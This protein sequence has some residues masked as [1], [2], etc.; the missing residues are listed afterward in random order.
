L[1]TNR[2]KNLEV[3]QRLNQKQVRLPA[4]V[5]SAAF[6][7]I[8][9]VTASNIIPI[10]AEIAAA[11]VMTIGIVRVPG[12][13][14]DAVYACINGNDS[15]SVFCEVRPDSNDITSVVRIRNFTEVW[16]LN[17]TEVHLRCFWKR[18]NN[19]LGVVAETHIVIGSPE[20]NNA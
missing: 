8:V 10:T 7:G 6:D 4:A 18:G 2:K 14:I 3:A 1:F 5:Q 16:I 17:E 11:N 15:A 12:C 13:Y 19:P 9:K 20:V